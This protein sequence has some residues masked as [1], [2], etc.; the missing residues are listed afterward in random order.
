ML[1]LSQRLSFGIEELLPLNIGEAQ[2]A[3]AQDSILL[4]KLGVCLV[5]LYVGFMKEYGAK[6][7]QAGNIDSKS[8]R[9]WLMARF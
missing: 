5:E 9:D 3:L 6:V 1:S 8:Q 7:E 4:S 2:N